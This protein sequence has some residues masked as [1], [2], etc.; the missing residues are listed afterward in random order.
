VRQDYKKRIDTAKSSKT[1]SE[2][3]AKDY[4]VDLQKYIDAAIREV[5]ILEKK[6]EEEIMKI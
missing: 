5:E 4:E 1:I 3:Q 6:K 2:D